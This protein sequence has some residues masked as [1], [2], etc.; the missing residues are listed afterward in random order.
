MTPIARKFA[1]TNNISATNDDPST[2]ALA[3][4]APE[5]RTTDGS[6]V[7]SVAGL[8]LRDPNALAS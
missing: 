2:R 5:S 4:V 1:K 8:S 7:F 6:G 3:A